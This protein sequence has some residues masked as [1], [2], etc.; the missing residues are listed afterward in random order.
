M[1]RDEYVKDLQALEDEALELGKRV[2][3]AIRQ[4]LLVLETRDLSARE[5]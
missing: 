2:S 4:G 3:D 5:R 1:T